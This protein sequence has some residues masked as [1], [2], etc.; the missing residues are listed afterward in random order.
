M[1]DKNNSPVKLGTTLAMAGK[2]E[3]GEK[4]AENVVLNI[5]HRPVRPIWARYYPRLD[6][7]ITRVCDRIDKL[8]G[9]KR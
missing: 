5:K 2:R 8:C 9:V 6:D 7:R 1:N 4:L 3:E